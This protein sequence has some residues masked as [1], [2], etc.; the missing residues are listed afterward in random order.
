[1]GMI[2]FN[3]LALLPDG[4]RTTAHSTG[5]TNKTQARNY[6]AELLSQG[7]LYSNAGMSFGV[8]AK[9]FFDNDSQWMGDKIQSGQ[10]KTQPVAANTLKSYRHSLETFLIPFF[11]KIKL[12]D[13]RPYHIKKFRTKLI[14]SNYSNSVINLSCTC[15]KIILS[16]AMADRLITTDP[17]ISVPVIYFSAHCCGVRPY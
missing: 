7:L 11:S 6:C 5:K 1:M 10:G 8:F 3:L 13:I 2:I 9:G 16:Y 15:L 4:E 17:F 12:S 14:E